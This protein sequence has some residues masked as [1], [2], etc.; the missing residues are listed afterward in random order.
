MFCQPKLRS[1]VIFAP[2]RSLF[3]HVWGVIERGMAELG[4]LRMG[5]LTLSSKCSATTKA[6][7][8]AAEFFGLQWLIVCWYTGGRPNNTLTMSNVI[9]QG[10]WNEMIVGIWGAPQVNFFG[11]YLWFAC[12]HISIVFSRTDPHTCFEMHLFTLKPPTVQPSGALTHAA[13]DVQGSTRSVT[14]RATGSHVPCPD[15]AG[16]LRTYAA[17][18]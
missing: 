3:K 11:L 1:K 6:A 14:S 10:Y 18:T 4:A 2:Q 5:G 15:E 16:L 8:P 13:V 9:C 17:M 12:R 7:F